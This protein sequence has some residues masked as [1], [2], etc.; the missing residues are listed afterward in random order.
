MT[1]TTVELP[2][3]ATIPNVPLCETGD[4]DAMTGP[5]TFTVADFQAAVAALDCP[6][7]RRPILKLGHVGQ[8]GQ[9]TMGAPAIGWVDNLHTEVD[10]NRLAGDYAG[11]PAWLAEILPSAYPDR[12]IEGTWDFKCALGHTHDFVIRAVALLGVDE[13]AVGTLAS[14]QDI[15]RLYDVSLAN[16][17]GN[18]RPFQTLAAKGEPVPDTRA[19]VS[20][21]DVRRTYYEGLTGDQYWWWIRELQLDPPQLIVDDDEGQLYRVPYTASGDEVTFGDPIPVRIQ[22][23]DSPTDEDAAAS[24]PHSSPRIFASREESGARPRDTSASTGSTENP[25]Q[26]GAG[27]DPVALRTS[28]GLPE[29]ASDEDVL[30]RA[31]ELQTASQQAPEASTTAPQL[32]EGVVAI[33]QTQL[34]Q[35]QSDAAAGRQA[36]EQQRTEAR[37]SFIE[38]AIQAG[39]IPPARRQFWRD[40]YDRDEVGARAFIDQAPQVIPTSEVGMSAGDPGA[41]TGTAGT[42]L[43]YDPRLFPELAYLHTPSQEG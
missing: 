19:S 12:S 11:M 33:D 39:K 30:T 26:E 40:Y 24:R 35:L 10:G 22:Y 31:A 27:V 13:P 37:N 42:D 21:E 18:G 1:V 6:A 23:V 38:E 8:H 4:W 36:R 16:D 9:P 25:E 17:T 20:V 3:L 43:G 15:A 2:V 7:V 14:L 41:D 32:P 28:L 29:D 5:V 34:Q